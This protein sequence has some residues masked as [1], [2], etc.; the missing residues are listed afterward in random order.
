MMLT[1]SPSL[2]AELDAFLDQQLDK[3]SRQEAIRQLMVQALSASELP[4]L[5]EGSAGPILPLGPAG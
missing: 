5:R 1:I 2:L 4:P 3:P